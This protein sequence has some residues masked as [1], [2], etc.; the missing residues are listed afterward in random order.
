MLALNQFAIGA[1]AFLGANFNMVL[2]CLTILQSLALIAKA[3]DVS[4]FGTT[5][6]Q[7]YIRISGEG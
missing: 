6:S 4:E 3:A 7:N 5:V 2:F 1:L